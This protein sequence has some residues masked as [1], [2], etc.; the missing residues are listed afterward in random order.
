MPDNELT[1]QAVA[2]AA[3]EQYEDELLTY[4][5]VTGVG[6]QDQVLPDGS[7]EP[8]VQVYVTQKLRPDE[9]TEEDLLPT[10][11]EVTVRDAA[12]N[13]ERQERIGV[14]VEPMSRLK[15]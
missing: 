2:R 9:L 12:G 14:Q 3:L 8:V 6:I 4:P 7:L 15:F 5:N 13:L 1:K 11:L 10:E